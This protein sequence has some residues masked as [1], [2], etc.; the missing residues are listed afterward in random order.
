MDRH[1]TAIQSLTQLSDVRSAGSLPP[2]LPDNFFQAHCAA[3]WHSLHPAYSRQIWLL[4]PP[5][6]QERTGDLPMLGANR[7]RELH[8]Q[9]FKSCQANKGAE[10]RQR[11][12]WQ[13]ALMSAQ[14]CIT[15]CHTPDSAS[16]HCPVRPSRRPRAHTV[17]EVN[18]KSPHCPLL[19]TLSNIRSP[20]LLLSHT[21]PF[22][23]NTQ[24][25]DTDPPKA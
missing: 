13:R 1:P 25:L 24:F 6:F 23:P 16:K 7:A 10:S 9:P 3:L 20:T 14:V 18:D 19:F 5:P 22:S 8:N 11:E 4:P 17:T 21:V 2:R 12:S 15:P